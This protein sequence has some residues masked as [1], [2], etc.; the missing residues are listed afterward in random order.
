MASSTR[1]TRKSGLFLFLVVLKLYINLQLNF[2]CNFVIYT[3]PCSILIS[4]KWQKLKS[5]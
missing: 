5:L 1:A 2:S 3:K 4:R